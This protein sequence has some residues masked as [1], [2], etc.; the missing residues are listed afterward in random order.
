MAAAQLRH[1]QGEIGDG[2]RIR[3][4]LEQHHGLRARQHLVEVVHTLGVGQRIVERQPAVGR[5]A[6]LRRESLERVGMQGIG[7]VFTRTGQALHPQ[8]AQR[9]VGAAPDHVDAL[10]EGGDLFDPVQVAAGVD[11]VGPRGKPPAVGVGVDDHPQCHLADVAGALHAAAGRAGRLHRGQQQP[12]QCGDDGHHHEQ[13][14]EREAGGAA[15]TRG[16]RQGHHAPRRRGKRGP[17]S[18]TARAART[19]VQRTF[20]FMQLCCTC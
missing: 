12:D 1:L 9:I 10:H 7:V 19:V 17:S 3:I 14:H 20:P 6:R 11:G 4:L 16:W 18:E 5:V 13:L 8:G 15:A 2:G